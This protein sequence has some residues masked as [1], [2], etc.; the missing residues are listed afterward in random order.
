V[1]VLALMQGHT[2]ERVA[3]APVQL[4]RTVMRVQVL[5]VLA[6][7]I[8]ATTTVAAAVVEP[9]RE[10]LQQ[11]VQ[12]AVEQVAR[13]QTTAQREPRTQA[14]AAAAA[15][16][17]AALLVMVHWVVVALCASA[18]SAHQSDRSPVPQTQPQKRVATPSIPSSNPETW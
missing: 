10:V 14:A 5:A 2:A 11:V 16:I 17:K 3:A 1:E 9:L 4:V 6:A 8:S 18:I 12:A 7:L 13:R 15:A